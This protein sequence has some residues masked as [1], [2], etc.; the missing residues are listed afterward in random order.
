MLARSSLQNKLE[1]KGFLTKPYEHNS[2]GKDEKKPQLE[3]ESKEE[4]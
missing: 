3:K 2:R 4:C 1:A